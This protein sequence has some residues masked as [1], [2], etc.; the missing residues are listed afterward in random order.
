MDR[1][2]KQFGTLMTLI[3]SGNADLYGFFK[4]LLHSVSQR[5]HSVSQR[6]N[7]SSPWIRQFPRGWIG[8]II[9]VHFFLCVF[10]VKTLI[11]ILINGILYKICSAAKLFCAALYKIS[12]ASDKISTKSGKISTKPKKIS[13][14]LYK[15][16][17]KPEKISVALYKICAVLY[18]RS[19]K[20]YK[21]SAAQYF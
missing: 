2:P 3:P 11:N 6:K 20:S 5:T 1:R 18:F 15:I 4:V 9:N 10:V 17:S 19:T 14:T 7:I 8:N 13:A 12:P 16:S 21:I